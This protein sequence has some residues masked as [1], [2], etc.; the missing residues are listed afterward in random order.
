VRWQHPQRGLMP[1]M[2]F[3]PMAE[4]TGLILPLGRWVL[5]NACRQARAWRDLRPDLPLFMSVNLSARQFAQPELVEQVAETLAANGL[6]PASLEIEITES[7]LMD[8]TEAGVRTLRELRE[9]DVRLVLDDFGTGYSSLSYLK[10]LPLDTIKIDR[11]FVAGMNGEVDRSI[12]EAVIG[13]AHGLGIGVVA[14]GIETND[15]AEQLRTMSC[16]LGQGYLFARPLPPAEAEMGLLSGGVSAERQEPADA[17]ASRAT[18]ARRR[19][20]AEAVPVVAGPGK[21]KAPARRRRS[22]GPRRPPKAA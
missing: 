13:L 5:E 20:P 1:P 11:M 16:D 10:H 12:V 2:S 9:L 22:A 4:E 18:P 14:E 8:Q 6:D 17:T 19:A 3:V 15:Q 7:I 21:G